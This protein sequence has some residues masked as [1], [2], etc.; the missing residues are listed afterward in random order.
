MRGMEF[1]SSPRIKKGTRAVART[2]YSSMFTILAATVAT[3]IAAGVMMIMTR[4]AHAAEFKVTK[5]A[6]TADGSCSS[7]DCS[8]REAIIAANDL[9][10]ADKITVPAGTYALTIP[11][12]DQT[13]QSGDL[14]I[15]GSVTIIGAGA[16]ATTISGEDT[17]RVLSVGDDNTNPTVSISGVTITRAGATSSSTEGNVGG[18]IY[19]SGT[20][21]LT[22]STLSGNKVSGNGS[23]G[24][25]VF[26]EGS[27]S[28]TVNKSTISG[29]E[30]NQGGGIYNSGSATGGGSVTITNSTISGNQAQGG[31]GIASF[32]S[33]GETIKNT[34]IARNTA[35]T[36]NG[37]G[38]F[39]GGDGPKFKNTIVAN[40]TSVNF[41]SDNCTF[42]STSHGNNLASDE[43]CDFD[44]QSDKQNTDP[45]LGPL[46]NNGG[47]TDTHAL[48]VGSPAINAAGKPFPTKD[49]R[50]VKRPQGRASDI[51]AVEKKREE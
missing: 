3:F 17:S 24:G 38:I 6:D 28:L 11:G 20:L 16:R 27:A 50:G 15:N 23:A 13:G 30:A 8:L 41:P 29:N 46:Q 18:G 31:G 12:G 9:G 34:T 39:S 47:P 14:N 26:N 49:Q 32:A 10:G 33:T 36:S 43:S 51:G 45:N 7:T 37:G 22:N 44:Q 4:P 1:C 2:S 25:G 19:N 48:G 40:N 21:T 42:S 5:T 35:T